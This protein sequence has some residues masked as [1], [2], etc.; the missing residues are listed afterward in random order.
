[1]KA[2]KTECLIVGSVLVA[3]LGAAYLFYS[4]FLRK[5]K[6]KV[7]LEDPN[8]KYEVPLIEKEVISHDTRRFRF[9]LPSNEHELGLN[10]GQHIYLSASIDDKLVIRPYTPVSS[11]HV[12]GYF[13][14]V[15][16]VYFKNVHPKYPDGGKM[17]QYLESLAIGDKIL[18]RG[19]NGLLIYKGKGKFAIRKNKTS[20]PVTYEYKKC[21]MIAGGTGITPMLQI[22]RAALE[23]QEDQTQFWLLF[24]NQSEKDILLRDELESLAKKHPSRFHLWYTV[25]RADDTWKY[26]VGFVNADMISNYLPPPDDSTII[27]LCGPP[28]MINFACNPNLDKLGYALQHR[29]AF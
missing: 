17:S 26:S 6:A 5:K 18:I 12:K 20:P 3:S 23:D 27:L 15:I 1:M 13:D 24:A 9:A 8:R 7:L 28:P 19:P 11:E 4:A 25:D 16:K 22:L 29:F 21:G 2:E 14:L 10:L